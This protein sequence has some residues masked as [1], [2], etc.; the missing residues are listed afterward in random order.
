MRFPLL[1]SCALCILAMLPLNASAEGWSLD[2]NGSRWGQFA[3]GIASGIVAHEAGHMLVATAKGYQVS[4]DGLSIT[5]PGAQYSPASHLQLA[6][7]GFQT[8]WVLSELVLRDRN[9]REHTKPPG[10]FG[11]GVVCSYIGVSFA[12]LTFLKNQQQG[13]VYGMSD[14]TGLSRDRIALMMAIPAVLDAW[15]LFG[16]DV[17]QWVPTLS[18]ASKG[19]GAAW[20]WTY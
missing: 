3:F 19:I 13:D 9:G 1:A 17:P 16:D 4:H 14:A 15:R 20:I 6:S 11:A 10:D 8:Q 7:A 5:Y 12:Y 18:V 2:D